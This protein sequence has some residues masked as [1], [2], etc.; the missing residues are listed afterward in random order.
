[1][2]TPQEALAL[3]RQFEQLLATAA[4]RPLDDQELAWVNENNHGLDIAIGIRYTHVAHSEV[5]AVI[6]VGSQHHQPWGLA[7]GGMYA[8]LVESTA[9]IAGVIAAGAPVVGVHNATDFIRGVS[10]GIVEAVATPVQ[11][12][13]STQL[14]NVDMNHE[15]KLCARGQLRTMVLRDGKS[16]FDA[17]LQLC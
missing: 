5:R 8:S 14:W 12:G 16:S 10:Q 3:R 2:T 7:N 4:E 9:S 6:N 15:G 1:M 13:G 17:R 11:L